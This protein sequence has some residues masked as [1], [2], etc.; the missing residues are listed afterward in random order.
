[1]L[2]LYG[3]YGYG[4]VQIHREVIYPFADGPFEH[5][6]FEEQ[7]LGEA[8]PTV[9][10]H[11]AQPG[12]PLILYFM[13]NR[14]ALAF[15]QPMLEWHVVNGHSVVAMGY[16]GG[17]GLA[18]PTTESALKEDA[19][20]VFDA[21]PSL[22]T[23]S[24][25]VIAQGFSLGTGLVLHIAARR[26]ID[27]VI[28]SAPYAKLCRIMTRASL[29]PACWLPGVDGWNSM[30]NAGAADVPVLILHGKQD[31]LIPVAEGQRLF[32]AFPIGPYAN[33]KM[34]EIEGAGHNN[35]MQQPT[36]LA[37]ISDFIGQL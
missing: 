26:D 11:N 21:L 33:R 23:G 1:M 14:G 28:L 25:T 24:R 36:Y 15:Y 31:D 35:M 19:I 20:A 27:G 37:S 9:Y 32:G 8:G 3:L 10:V 6:A 34:V 29:L 17:G 2:A 12:A 5:P 13:G 7:Q 22:V 18:G 30:A 4:M 16:R